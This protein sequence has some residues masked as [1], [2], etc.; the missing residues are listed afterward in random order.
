MP[1]QE[2]TRR[3]LLA[4]ASAAI[5]THTLLG[6]SA[7]AAPSNPLTHDLTTIE[8]ASGGRLGVAILNTATNAKTLYRADERF[9]MCSTFKLL[10]AAAILSRVDAGKEHL[11]RLITYQHSDLVDYSPVTKDHTGRPGMSLSDLCAAAI[12]LSDNT[13][14]NLLLAAIDGPPGLTRFARSLGDT[15]TR[16]D[17]NEPTLN[18]AIPNDPRD[19]TTPSAMLADLNALVFGSALSTSSRIQLT[20]WLLANKTGTARLRAGLPTTWRI[21]DKTGSGDNGTTNDI[22]ILWPPHAAPL[23]ACVF[24]TGTKATADQRNATLAA[25]ARALANSLENQGH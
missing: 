21:G 23:I 8:Q 11:D 2:I 10:A 22:A 25:V 18:T 19:T 15:T 7:H 12:T 5:L 24:L 14:G 9:P 13:A 4:S 20:Q 1:P 17:R 3:R 16:L 6:E